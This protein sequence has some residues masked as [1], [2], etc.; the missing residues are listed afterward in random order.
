MERRKKI[1]ESLK[2]R[3]N[4]LLLLE[5]LKSENITYDE[6]EEIGVKLKNAGKRALSPLVRRLWREKSGDLISKYTYLLDF[7]E[8]EAWLDQL[9]QITLR[10][11]DLEEDGKAAFLAALEG[12]GVDVTSPPF[13]ELLAE[14]GG[15]LRTTLPRLLDKGTEG[16]ISFMEEFLFAS[17]EM[18]RAIIRELPYVSDPRVL[19]ILEILL[20]IDEPEI[21]CETVHALGKTR[22]EGSIPLLRGLLASKDGSVRKLAEKSLRRLSFLGIE[23]IPLP[24]PKSPALPFY[25]TCVTPFDGAGYRLLWFS[26]WSAEG[27]LS[28]LFL[29]IHEKIGM[30][31][32]W[33]NSRLGINECAKQREE[34]RLEDGILE[35][36][37][38]YA[39]NLVNDAIYRSRMQGALL[40]AEFYVMA[41]MFLE[42]EIAPA[43]YTPDFRDYNPPAAAVVSRQIARSASL[44]DDECFSAWFISSPRVYDYAEEWMEL[45]KCAGK[46]AL[47][48]EMEFL[49]ERFCGEL[50]APEMET[51]RERMLLTADLML[52]T[53]R[54][55]ELVRQ[56]LAVALNLTNSV[57]PMHRHPFLKCYALESMDMAR[58]ALA[59]GYD[60]REYQNGEDEWE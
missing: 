49:V 58:E 9:I 44:F 6:I 34:L 20:R 21:V 53:G 59:E 43:P 1:D 5:R 46:S 29:Q 11:R 40:P 22:E 37:P 15:P 26:R 36:A 51:I 12:Y 38:E 25:A 4:I 35:I 48:K 8:D 45:E 24:L 3:H 19:L 54:D 28:S 60:P 41:G 50:L 57:L 42:G 52:R 17:A 32:A 18:R 10:R 16:L 13:A 31:A 55:R 27:G 7:F 33:G 14:I 47:V 2:E 30:T 39:L 56:T 23:S